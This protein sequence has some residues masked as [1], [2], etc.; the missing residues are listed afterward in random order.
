MSKFGTNHILNVF[1]KQQSYEITTKISKNKLKKQQYNNKTNSKVKSTITDDE[2]KSNITDDEFKSIM[3]NDD[4]KKPDTKFNNSRKK[5]NVPNLNNTN[6][7]NQVREILN[8]NIK[9]DELLHTIELSH[10]YPNGIELLEGIL[11]ELLNKFDTDIS[12]VHLN[13]YGIVL[14]KLF[15]SNVDE[16]VI[17]LVMIHKYCS[18]C[19]FPKIIYKNSSIYLIKVL[20]Q[21]FFTYDIFEEDSYWKWQEYINES[22]DFDNELK[23]TL[24]IQTAEFF[25]ILKTVFT[26]VDYIQNSD[27]EL[28]DS[29]LSSNP[30]YTNNNKQSNQDPDPDPDPEP[31]PNNNSDFEIPEEQDYNLDEMIDNI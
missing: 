20:F 3:N 30:N 1:N 24:A 14:K 25:N 27:P 29:D 11:I 8:K 31:E 5:Y 9:G 18:K 22:D 23:Q 6:I 26:D 7:N 17:G 28:N 19:K 2:F 4:S 13:N 16:Q 21:L 10:N 15:E 12:W